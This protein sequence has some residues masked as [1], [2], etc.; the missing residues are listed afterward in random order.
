MIT[1]MHADFKDFS[2][3]FIAPKTKPA[4]G[5][6][7]A[8]ESYEQLVTHMPGHVVGVA[9]AAEIEDQ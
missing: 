5:G 1:Q 7:E 3:D 9:S 6:P 8:G 2:G 4:S